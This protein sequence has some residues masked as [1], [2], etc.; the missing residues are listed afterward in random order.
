MG[1]GVHSNIYESVGDWYSQKY[2]VNPVGRDYHDEDLDF[3]NW[4]DFKDIVANGSQTF[5]ILRIRFITDSGF[6]FYDLSYFHVR[7]DGKKTEILDSPFS[8]VNKK[9]FKNKLYEI[10][11]K[12]GVYLPNFFSRV[13]TLK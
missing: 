4:D 2:E 7:I 11:K 5:E 1:T 6:P 8:Q 10:L 9:F 3:M 13:S 12:E